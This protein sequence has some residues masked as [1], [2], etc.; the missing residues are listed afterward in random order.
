M[1]KNS[2]ASRNYNF[3]YF[4]SDLRSWRPPTRTQFAMPQSTTTVWWYPRAVRFGSHP[5][6][7]PLPLLPRPLTLHLRPA[8][9]LHPALRSSEHRSLLTSTMCNAY[10][11]LRF[12]V[13]IQSTILGSVFNNLSRNRI[14]RDLFRDRFY[15]VW[16]LLRNHFILN[17]NLFSNYFARYFGRRRKYR[18]AGWI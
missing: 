18:V 13:S 1:F 4:C 12:Y 3:L 15:I 8:L 5:L 17:C 14:H 16:F 2:I 7:T 6:F 10:V 9:H 11:N